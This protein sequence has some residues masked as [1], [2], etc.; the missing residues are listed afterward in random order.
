MNL[1]FIFG[2]RERNM[3]FFW[4]H[5]SRVGTFIIAPDEDRFVIL[6][7]DESLGSYHSPEAA[8]DD[9]VGGHTFSPSNG[10]DT[11]EVGLPDELSA[12]TKVRRR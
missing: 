1:D 5:T 6:Y 10:V 3:D 7:E 8:L 4:T 11:S 12:W 2:E 9:L